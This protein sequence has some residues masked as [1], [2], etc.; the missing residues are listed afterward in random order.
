MAFV[1]DQQP[2]SVAVR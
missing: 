1:I 2:C